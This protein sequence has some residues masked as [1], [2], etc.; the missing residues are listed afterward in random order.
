MANATDIFTR[1]FKRLHPRTRLEE[2]TVEFRPFANVNSNIRFS[3]ARLNVRISDM[4]EAAPE[5]VLEALAFILISKLYRQPVAGQYRYRY[6]R[7]IN[8]GSMRRQLHL[9]RQE[10]GRKQALTAKGEFYDLEEIFGQL[11]RRYFNG[12]LGMPVLGWSLAR[13]RVK[14]GHFDP[15]HNTIV[16]SRLFDSPRVPRLV[17]EYLLYHEMLHLKHPVEHGRIR[18]RVHSSDFQDDERRF[19]HYE[20]ARHELNRLL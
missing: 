17:L 19:E 16:L 9:V 3:E 2:V 1:V 15:S 13:S 8:A 18:R 7:F 10:R 11:N 14:L 6:Q 20:A 12:L 4:L 5:S